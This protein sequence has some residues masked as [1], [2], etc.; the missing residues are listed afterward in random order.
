[1]PEKCN[2]SRVWRLERNMIVFDSI[3]W[4]FGHYNAYFVLKENPSQ[5]NFDILFLLYNLTQNLCLIGPKD[6][7]GKSLISRKRYEFV[8]ITV[9]D[10]LCHLVV[11]EMFKYIN[12]RLLQMTVNQ[13]YMLILLYWLNKT[14]FSVVVHVHC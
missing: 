1:M 12:L 6:R 7:A 10:M 14:F 5:F 9:V 13:S 11:I 2:I 4:D 8:F 3:I